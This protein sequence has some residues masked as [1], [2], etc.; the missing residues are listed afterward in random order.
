MARRTLALL[1]GTLAA[2]WG[3]TPAK[4]AEA[5]VNATSAAQFYTYSSP[6]G[7]PTVRR[8]RY[9]QTLSL[10]VY[11]ITGD[12][13]AFEPDLSFKMRLRLDAD[14]GQLNAERDPNNARRFVPGLE[15]AP[16]DVMY[17]YLEGNHYFDG[18][19]GFRLGR[20]YVTD[21][22]GWWSFDGGLVRLTMPAYIQAEV[23]GGFEQR[24]GLPAMLGT[25]R[26]SGDG[27]YRGNREDLELGFYPHYLEESQ[28]APAYGFALE[29]TGVH[30]LKARLSYRKVINRDTVVVSPFRAPDGSFLK[31]GGDRVSSER[32]GYSM[33]L[34]ESNLG[35]LRG[36][37]VY[38]FYNQVVSDYALALDWYA[39]DQVTLGADYDYYYPTF[40]G[41]SIWNWFSHSGMTTVLGR[42]E[43]RHS[44]IWD[45]AASGGMRFFRTEGDSG[46]YR[47]ESTAG[48]DPD[49][50]QTGT[51][52]DVM[53]SLGGRYRWADGGVELRGMGEKGRRGHRVGGDVTT[54]QA[55]EGRYDA[56][57]ILSLYDWDDALRP[58]RDATSFSYVLG[59]GYAPLERTR[60]GLE[61]EHAMN[62][63]VGQRFRALATLD[64]TVLN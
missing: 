20:Q 30:F 61:W 53:G 59:G 38:D 12:R 4:A 31:V 8:R 58:S 44:R 1:T 19:V 24:G 36:S 2:V 23:Y 18:L 14:F 57:V 28:L 64:F 62:R 51:L 32:I 63:L 9:T 17:A 45:V 37:A 7:E 11:D 10:H 42:A 33:R 5:E 60:I 22:L 21:A 54:R 52:G 49:R 47:A 29:S 50:S 34:S 3:A 25:S 55:F 6:F 41:D 13:V 43:Y 46:T 35:G 56:M 39:T 27:V 15:Q 40:D 26:Y 48:R 16:L